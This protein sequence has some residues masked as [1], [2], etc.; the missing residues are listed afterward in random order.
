MNSVN[1]MRLTIWAAETSLADHAVQAA[2]GQIVTAKGS[3]LI[4]SCGD[5]STLA[6]SDLQLE[7]RRRLSTRDFLNGIS[8]R[9]G[10]VLGRNNE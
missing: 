2:P 5:K 9:E 6:I 7:G 1:G 8:I 3:D 4:V 10:E